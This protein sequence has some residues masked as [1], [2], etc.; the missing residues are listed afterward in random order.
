LPAKTETWVWN[1]H[2]GAALDALEELGQARLKRHEILMGV[3]IIPKSL[4]PE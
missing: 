1:L 3:F 4:R 2:P